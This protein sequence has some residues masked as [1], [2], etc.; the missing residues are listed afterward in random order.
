MESVDDGGEGKCVWLSMKFSAYK[1]WVYRSNVSGFEYIMIWTLTNILCVEFLYLVGH[2]RNL[3][4]FKRSYHMQYYH[5]PFPF[6]CRLTCNPISINQPSI[7]ARYLLSH[8][9]AFLPTHPPFASLRAPTP[10]KQNTK[11]L[12]W[13]KVGAT[14]AWSGVDIEGVKVGDAKVR[15]LAFFFT[16]DLQCL[17]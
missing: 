1:W 9:P 15:F 16:F 14:S 5:G 17:C 2:R 4:T 12:W 13:W 3:I 6:P 8:P 11:K 10:P 7:Y